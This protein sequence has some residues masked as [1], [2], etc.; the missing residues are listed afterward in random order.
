MPKNCIIDIKLLARI[1]YDNRTSPDYNNMTGKKDILA[2]NGHKLARATFDKH[3]PAIKEEIDKLHDKSFRGDAKPAERERMA[4][5]FQMIDYI[6]GLKNIWDGEPNTQ[7]KF[8]NFRDKLQAG[9][10]AAEFFGW[11]APAKTDNTHDV[12]GILVEWMKAGRLKA[13]NPEGDQ[14]KEFKE[15][16]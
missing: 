1:L 2:A 12:T 16:L 11:N 9:K 10:Q 3:Y 13:F 5:I 8:P 15:I 6:S 7:G 4:Q 14:N